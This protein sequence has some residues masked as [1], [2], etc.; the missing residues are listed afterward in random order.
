[1]RRSLLTLGTFAAAGMVVSLFAGQAQ[2]APTCT[3][4]VVATSGES[5]TA[6]QLGTAGFCVQAADKVFGNF[7]GTGG[8]GLASAIFT[9]AN[10][11]G[12][13]TVGLSD[14]IVGTSNTTPTVATVNY[15]VALT[16]GAI[17]LG[18]RI[19]DLQKDITLNATDVTGFATATLTGTTV[20]VT[21]P[22]VN[23]SCVR[24][25]NPET[26]STCPEDVVFSG[27]T[28]FTIHETVTAFAN[29]T[30]TGLTDT[31]SQK[32]P[33]PGTLGLLGTGLLGLGL[34]ARRRRR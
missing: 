12:N 29:T 17:A 22:P 16:P 30:V 5:F 9:F 19:E 34:L 18:W 20:P 27:I 8:T 4:T 31:I 6:A 24:N 25:V 28:D 7:S 15:E 13:V 1:M 21:V 33:E 26:G 3:T 14:A 10:P 11:F 32:V 2:A 23:I